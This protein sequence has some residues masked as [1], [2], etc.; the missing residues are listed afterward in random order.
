MFLIL[1]VVPQ[2][3]GIDKFRG[4]YSV[5]HSPTSGGQLGLASSIMGSTKKRIW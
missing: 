4:H 1:L 2:S 3:V 5:D